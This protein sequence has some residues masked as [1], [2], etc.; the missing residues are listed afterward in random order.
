MLVTTKKQPENVASMVMTHIRDYGDNNPKGELFDRQF[1][2]NDIQREILNSK[3]SVGQGVQQMMFPN[4]ISPDGYSTFLPG[5]MINDDY[6]DPK[7]VQ[8][9]IAENQV[10]LYWRNNVERVLKYNIIATRSE[11]NESLTQ[12]CNE[13]IYKDDLGDIC[14]LE[15]N[16][17]AG[18]GETVKRDLQTIFKRDVLRRIMKFQKNGWNYMKKLLIEGRLFL[19]VVFDEEKQEITGVNMLPSQNMI[20]VVQDNMIIGYRQ[21]LDGV[22]AHSG[23][24]Y[25][26]FSPNQILFLSL[27][28]YG[29][30]GVNDPRSIL[31][32]AMKPHNQLNTI[33]DSVVMYRILWG[34]EKMVLKVDVAGMPKPQAERHM[35]EQAKIFSRQIDYNTTTGEITN[36]GKAIGLSEHFILPVTS[37]SSGS[38][39]ERLQGG[40]QLGNIDDL[41]FFKRNLV[42]SLMV[43][44]GRITALAGDGAN[45]TNGKIGEV[46]QA[47]VAFARLVQRY[48]TPIEQALVRLFI[49]VLNTKKN[50]DDSIKTEENFDIRFKRSN[51]FQNFIDADVWST[52]LQVFSSMMEWAIKDETPSNPLSQEFCLR[53][54]L[55]ISDADLTQNRK[56]REQESEEILGT[57]GAEDTGV[58]GAGDLGGDFSSGGMEDSFGGGESTGF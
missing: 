18:I 20:V 5:I 4:G 26:D 32:P 30:G 47:E 12:I 24:N 46:T 50:F 49:M 14:T 23:K 43:P 7:R 27:D 39:I 36:Y 53:Y 3:N 56:W 2:R 16:E 15:I 55:R 9:S 41:K 45:Y 8:D 48:Q 22:Y 44:P 29:P 54:G 57:S 35:K 58:A 52:R 10:Q 34:S 42:N 28:L 51:G 17:Y 40:E 38:N 19:E 25:I 6:V 13:A 33:E 37:N 1:N 11:V 21:M 31:E